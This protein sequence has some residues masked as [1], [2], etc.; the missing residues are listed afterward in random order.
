[1]QLLL[2]HAVGSEL[3][4]FISAKTNGSKNRISMLAQRGHSVH[5]RRTV[6]PRSWGQ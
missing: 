2:N 1:M 6:L 3:R 4:N 5:A